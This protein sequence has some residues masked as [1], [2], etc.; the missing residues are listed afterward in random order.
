MH[1]ET[2]ADMTQ[3]TEPLS[4]QIPQ[5]APSSLPMKTRFVVRWLAVSS[6]AQG[7]QV[8]FPWEAQ[9]DGT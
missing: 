6:L 5:L 7:L 1:D 2:M 8:A 9:A 3:G 4:V